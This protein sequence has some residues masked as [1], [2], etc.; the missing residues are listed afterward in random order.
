MASALSLRPQE[1]GYLGVIASETWREEIVGHS[2]ALHSVLDTIRQVAPSDTTVLL[3]GETGTGKELIARALHRLSP[4]DGRP[5]VAVNCGAIAPGLIESELFGHERGAF[6]G[7]LQRRIGRFESADQSTLFLDEVSELPLDGQV[8]LL[9]AVQE[10]EI[11][12]VGG[13]RPIRVDVRLIAATNRD[14]EREVE[15]GRLR[16]DL[17]YRLNVLPIHIPPLRERRGDIPQLARHFVAHFQKKLGKPFTGID[18]D[19]MR[20]L[21]AHTWPGNVRELRNVIERACVLARG[22]VITIEGPLVPAS[23]VE[24]A[25]EAFTSLADHERAYLRRVL[26]HTKGRISGPRGAAAILEVHP[27]TLRSRLDRLGL[28]VR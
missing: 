6:T 24:D 11:E 1:Y 28:T 26:M 14:L 5:L 22:P 12:R 8:K 7:A 21:Q 18:P 19:S 20:R 23:R 16:P 4:R 13:S 10:Q 17:F 25:E 3:I 9:R 27:N 15:A 2:P